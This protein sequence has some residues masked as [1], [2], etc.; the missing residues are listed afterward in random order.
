MAS[1]VP[2]FDIACNLFTAGVH[3]DQNRLVAQLP[4]RYWEMLDSLPAQGTMREEQ[5]LVGVNS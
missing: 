1:G 5:A 2:D 4:L 3:I